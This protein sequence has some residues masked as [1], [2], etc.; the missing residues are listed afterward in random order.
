MTEP[1]A[2]T[3]EARRGGDA[4]IGCLGH[5]TIYYY[6]GYGPPRGAE[7]SGRSGL[8]T[9]ARHKE[10][11]C[12]I[13]RNAGYKEQCA[14]LVPQT[15]VGRPQVGRMGADSRSG[16]WGMRFKREEGERGRLAWVRGERAFCGTESGTETA[17][18]KAE[19]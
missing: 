6:A 11:A 19:R 3:A 1:R 13:L 17:E 5:C 15:A 10:K 7:A 18:G 8:R 14:V 12:G 2:E 9:S 16:M 4:R